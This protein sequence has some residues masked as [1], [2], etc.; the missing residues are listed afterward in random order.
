MGRGSGDPNFF[1]IFQILGLKR[2]CILKTRL[3]GA[4][5]VSYKFICGVVVFLAQAALRAPP[6]VAFAM[7]FNKTILLNV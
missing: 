2:C 1:C 7:F 5:E 6:E 3:L 4:K